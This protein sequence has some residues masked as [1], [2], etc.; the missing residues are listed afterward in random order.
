MTVMT[1]KK[2][3]EREKNVGVGWGEMCWGLVINKLIIIIFLDK[4]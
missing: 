3:E 2:E 1:W 4:Y